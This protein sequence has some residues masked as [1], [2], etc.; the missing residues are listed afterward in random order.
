MIVM[1]TTVCRNTVVTD[2]SRFLYM[3]PDQTVCQ[4]LIR[5]QSV[6]N[7]KKTANA[8]LISQLFLQ[9]RLPKAVND[10]IYHFVTSDW[11]TRRHYGMTS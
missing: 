3:G 7:G 6:F 1:S 2:L 8:L 9:I 5:Q 10:D 4:K 11:I